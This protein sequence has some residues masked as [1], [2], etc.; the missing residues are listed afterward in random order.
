MTVL[1]GGTGSF[2]VLSG[3]VEIPHVHVRSIVSM[4]D[5]GGDS[6]RLR[7]EYG[8]LPPGDLRRCLVALSRQSG[9]FRE[10]FSYRFEAPPLDGR[11][12]GNLLFL[13]LSQILDSEK[14]ACQAMK[15]ILKVRGDVHAVTWD[16]VH[17]HARLADG[18]VLRGESQID[19]PE[20]DSRIP[21]DSVY[22][23]PSARANEDA[24]ASIETG[25]LLVL[26]PGDLFTSSIPNL[27]VEGIP[28]ALD[29]S[30]SPLVYIVNLMTK[31]GETDGYSAAAHVA[32]LVRYG[33]RIPDAVLVHDG[34]LPTDLAAKY[35]AEQAV[36]V[37][38]DEHN[39]RDL[40]VRVIKRANLM[41]ATSLVR[42]DPAR[43]AQALLELYSE[44]INAGWRR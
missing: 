26:A 24:V 6:G 37:R 41:S 31:H 30:G 16:H 42:H 2:S 8:V 4:M 7:D 22:L 44:L 35:Q 20:H 1:G 23:E 36:R 21:I 13:A 40:G 34:D 15:T 29:R 19:V 32:Q 14:D 38:V 43:T 33:R 9:L 39:L 18:T 11:N 10:L 28:H 27:L 12:F 25:D 5:S 3:L 17:L